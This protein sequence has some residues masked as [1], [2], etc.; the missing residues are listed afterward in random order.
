[1]NAHVKKRAIRPS[2]SDS[3][4]KFR[5]GTRKRGNDGNVYIISADKNGKKR[6]VK[7]ASKE[8]VRSQTTAAKKTSEISVTNESNFGPLFM[9]NI[10]QASVVRTIAF[11]ISKE[12]KNDQL[13]L[14]LEKGVAT[15]HL[16]RED[17]DG[18]I[19]GINII[20][21][22]NKEI[23]EDPRYYFRK[24]RFTFRFQKAYVGYDPEQIREK[25]WWQKVTGKDNPPWYRGN[26]VL[27]QLSP[28]RYVVAANDD[29]HSFSMQKGEQI[30]A[31]VSQ[32]GNSSVPYP[33]AVS[34]LHAYDTTLKIKVP[35]ESVRADPYTL[36]NTPWQKDAVDAIYT[37]MVTASR[38]KNDTSRSIYAHK[39]LWEYKG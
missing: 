6:W 13:P 23:R 18:Y 1:M 5:I 27:L 12:N 36:K 10:K 38:K 21:I 31:F 35:L 19:D 8:R 28:E 34:N 16:L 26:A 29:V 2:P 11:A 39:V 22:N 33:Y 7:D 4:T 14:V 32:I 20:D 24:P 30:T 17:K 37:A 9:V 3:A 15:I 25:N